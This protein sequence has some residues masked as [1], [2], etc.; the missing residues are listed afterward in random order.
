LLPLAANLY[1]AFVTYPA[2]M[3]LTVPGAVSARS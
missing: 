3:R 1:A 2:T